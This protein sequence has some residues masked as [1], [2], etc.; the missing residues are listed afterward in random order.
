MMNR[1]IV[2]T[3]LLQIGLIGRTGIGRLYATGIARMPRIA[4]LTAFCDTDLFHAQR[5]TINFSGY[6]A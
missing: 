3:R 6:A 4:A 1:R 2:I 5:N